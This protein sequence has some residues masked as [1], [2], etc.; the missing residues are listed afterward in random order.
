MKSLERPREPEYLLSLSRPR[1]RRR[2]GDYLAEGGWQVRASG[3]R[4]LLARWPDRRLRGR[5]KVN[6]QFSLAVW[7]GMNPGVEATIAEPERANPARRKRRAKAKLLR[8]PS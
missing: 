5:E 6:L 2:L 1:L 3:R 4:Q 7:Q 8:A